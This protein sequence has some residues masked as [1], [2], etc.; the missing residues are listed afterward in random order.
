VTAKLLPNGD[1]LVVGADP[2]VWTDG[3]SPD[4]IADESRYVLRLDWNGRVLWKRRLTAHHD[5][6]PTPDGKLLAVTFERR[7]AQDIHPNIPTRDD[8]LTILDQDGDVVA[9]HSMLDAVNRSP[10]V[11]PLIGVKPSDLGGPPWIDLFHSNSVEWIRDPSLGG[12]LPGGSG[13]I[14]VCFR[15]QSRIAV[16]DWAENRVVWTWG[17]GILSGPHDAHVLETGNILLFDNG[18]ARKASRVIELDPRTDA[19]V[20]KWEANPPTSFFTASKGSAQR[21][22]NGNT[23]LCESDR[24]RAFEITPEGTIVWAFLCPHRTQD[25]ERAAIVHMRRLPRELIDG[26]LRQAAAP[27]PPAQ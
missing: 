2:H 13:R 25:G 26:I 3:G 8:N 23:L 4:R 15:H 18:V 7:I 14:L 20:W 16:F 19:I 6:A 22:P 10:G 27:L 1:L 5:I 11:F 17:A 24:G 12:R 9:S 21:L